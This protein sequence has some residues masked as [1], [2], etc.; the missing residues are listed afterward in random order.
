M[1]TDAK[2]TDFC[3]YL[4]AVL[5]VGLLLN[6]MCLIVS[7]WKTRVRACYSVSRPTSLN[8]RK[9]WS[10]EATDVFSVAA[11]AAFSPQNGP[12]FFDSDP[13][14]PGESPHD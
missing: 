3:A 8:F 9:S 12:L 1:V 7:H 10:N 4:S 11:V 13:G 6:A 2:Q 5:L 14:H